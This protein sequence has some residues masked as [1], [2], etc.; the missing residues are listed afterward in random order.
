MGGKKE[1]GTSQGKKRTYLQVVQCG[2]SR[3]VRWAVLGNEAR[4]QQGLDHAW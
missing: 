1:H 2:Y 4:G 3:G